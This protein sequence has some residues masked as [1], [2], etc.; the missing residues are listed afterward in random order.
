MTTNCCPLFLFS[1]KMCVTQLLCH[2]HWEFSENAG[3]KS[4]VRARK[5]TAVCHCLV[6]I[7]RIHNVKLSWSCTATGCQFC[8]GRTND[9]LIFQL[10]KVQLTEDRVGTCR[11]SSHLQYYELSVTRLL[12]PC[13]HSAGSVLAASKATEDLQHAGGVVPLK[14]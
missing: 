5:Q 10:P 9:A 13:L 4:Q 11:N 14:E 2:H 3:L 7:Q 8:S 1:V 12:Y 6:G